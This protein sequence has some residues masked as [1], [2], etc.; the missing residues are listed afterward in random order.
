MVARNVVLALLGVWFT[1]SS[2]ILSLTHNLAYLWTGVVL[3][4][5]TLAG[6]LWALTDRKVLPWRHGLMAL[7]GLWFALSPWLL[8]FAQRGADLGV[9]LVLGAATLALCL[10]EAF[11]R[12][13]RPAAHGSEKA[14]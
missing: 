13:T 7:F 3:G 4:L 12:G 6:A 8:G 11:G 9:T 2:W 5:L 14:A 1:V 10:W